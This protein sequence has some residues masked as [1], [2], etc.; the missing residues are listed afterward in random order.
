MV[1][2]TINT[3]IQIKSRAKPLVFFGKVFMFRRCRI[4]GV[5]VL[6]QIL[7]IMSIADWGEASTQ[8]SVKT[9]TLAQSINYALSNNRKFQISQ[10]DVEL[11]N[12]KVK[13]ARAAFLPQLMLDTG[14]TF[15]GSLPKIVL[16]GDFLANFEDL[17]PEEFSLEKQMNDASREP[18]EFELGVKHS[19]QG[20]A[21]T[22]YP[23]F[24]WGKIRNT[25]RQ[26]VLGKQAASRALDAVHLDVE[27]QVRQAFY[28]LLLVEAF[29][30]VAERSIAQVEKR[31][32]RAQEQKTAGATTQLEV[33]RA[34]VQ[35]VN[36]RSQLIQARNK[37]K[38]AKENFKLT[39][40]LPLDESISINGKLHTELKTVNIDEAIAT[41][42]ERRPKLQQVKV[43]EQIGEK[44]VKVAEAGNKP[45]LSAF[46]KYT[47]N[48]NERQPFNA[49]WSVGLVSQFP[50]FDG[51]ATQA[52][53]NQ[54]R[55]NLDQIRTNKDQLRDSIK[56]EVKST[57]F[58]LQAAQKLIEVQEGIV[59][60]AAEG[61]RIAN[62]QHKAGLIT[63][64]EL[65][66][67]ELSHT[68]AQVNRLQAIHDYIIAVARLERAISTRLQ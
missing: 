54:A 28:G 2:V 19:L 68:Q 41:A 51:F 64:V 18:I 57:V 52:K 62:V 22:T 7:G 21:Q 13:E 23:L 42:L 25:Y 37:Q 45:T 39:L 6:F 66:D 30:D 34:N 8:E 1:A 31:Y 67:V 59:E 35:V 40:G 55:V 53:V 58:D 49:S 4:F 63:G 65:T 14:Y 29:I 33:I 26:A 12:E 16:D 60:E 17:L 27:L 5:V 56:L 32:K 15:S 10:K 3:F 50:I 20:Q 46:G 9:F 24:T 61:L 44:H 38:L 43:Q 47:F 48:R 11:A 36:A